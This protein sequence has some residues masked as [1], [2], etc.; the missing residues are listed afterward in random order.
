MLVIPPGVADQQS[1]QMIAIIMDNLM[2]LV[3]PGDEV[4][5]LASQATHISH[6][7]VV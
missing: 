5:T 1:L 3:N 6:G 7:I 4:Y 2:G